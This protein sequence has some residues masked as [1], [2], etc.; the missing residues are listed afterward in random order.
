M[1]R[2]EKERATA[3]DKTETRGKRKKKVPVTRLQPNPPS[4]VSLALCVLLCHEFTAF[5]LSGLFFWIRT[6][7]IRPYFGAWGDGWIQ[8]LPVPTPSLPKRET[9]SSVFSTFSKIQLLCNKVRRNSQVPARPARLP[10]AA[11]LRG[12]RACVCCGVLFCLWVKWL[13]SSARTDDFS[14]QPLIHLHINTLVPANTHKLQPCGFMNG[15]V[16]RDWL[17]QHI[18]LR[19]VNLHSWHWGT[20]TPPLT[21]PMRGTS[22]HLY[23]KI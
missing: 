13:I 11:S 8:P 12:G 17:R 22:L 10:L 18:E 4:S 20:F 5:L 15:W 3:R 1:E 9:C 21:T 14:W 6:G 2:K 23:S 19:G 7:P 16:V